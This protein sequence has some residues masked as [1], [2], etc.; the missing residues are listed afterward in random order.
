MEITEIF[1]SFLSDFID[2]KKRIFMGYLFLSLAIAYLWLVVIR[3]NSLRNAH[4]QIF[5]RKV[6]FSK[7]AQV[8]YKIFFINRAFSLFISP[9][10]I[11]QIAIATVIYYT[12]HRQNIFHSGQFSGI[13]QALVIT[14]FSMAMFAVDDFTKYFVH[15]WMHNW[16][17]LWAFHKVHHSAETMTPITV[18]RVHPAEGILFGLR[19]AVSQGIVLSI[20]IFLFGNAVDLYT[21]VGVNILVFF[22][23][24]TGSNLRHSHINIRYWKWLEYIFISPAQH[25][26]HHSI[27]EEHYDKNFGAA[28]AVWDWLFG[29]LH[30]SESDQ[31]ITY[32]LTQD[33]TAP[34]SLSDMYFGPF[35]DTLNIVAKYLT[36]SKKN[37]FSSS[38]EKPFEA[39]FWPRN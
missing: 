10:L 24:M 23:H 5:N 30:L 12:L 38:T 19:S 9:L 14:L 31:E 4:F 16:S 18:Y 28:L 8:D 29:S 6:F 22:F 2:P 35:G 20:F 34:K 3:K 7:S 27:A 36:R 21:I 26:L 33:P 15:R 1:N 39:R 13:N 25:Q 11:T 37:L 32:G 17:L